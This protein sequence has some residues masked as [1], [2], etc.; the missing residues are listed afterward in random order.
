MCGKI[1]QQKMKN[2]QHS[3]KTKIDKR[4]NQTIITLR[5]SGF[6][7]SDVSDLKDVSL[8]SLPDKETIQS[9]VGC[10]SICF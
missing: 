5:F 9:F 7:L 3:I 2:L 1:I 8:E 10:I 4:F 6:S